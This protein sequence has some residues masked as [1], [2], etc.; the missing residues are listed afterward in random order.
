MPRSEMSPWVVFNPTMPQHAAGTRTE[1]AVSVPKLTSARPTAVATAEPQE[2]PPGITRCHLLSGL[3][4]V[5]KYSFIPEGVTANSLRFVF[6]TMLTPR[7][8][9]IARH[10]ASWFA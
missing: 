1:P 8:R 3:L 4:G 5:P 9:A 2:E 6:P 7:C 10:G